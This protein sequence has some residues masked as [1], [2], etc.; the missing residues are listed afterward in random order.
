MS[1]ATPNISAYAPF[2]CLSYS[3]VSSHGAQAKGKR[4][5]RAAVEN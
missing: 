3:I 4:D 2:D 1:S 5:P